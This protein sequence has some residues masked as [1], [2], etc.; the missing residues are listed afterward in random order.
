MPKNPLNLRLSLD[1]DERLA[2]AAGGAMRVFADAA[3][4]PNDNI[5]QLKTAVVSACKL[6]FDFHDNCET[7]CQVS[8]RRLDDRIEV[9][10]TV[11]GVP[12]PA[13]KPHPHWAGVDDI[14]CENRNNSGVLRLTKF[15]QAAS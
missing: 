10:V 7:P 3:G 2:A 13:E 15:L 11:P 5:E 12:P 9:E 8:F 4:L 14:Q 6:C 1:H